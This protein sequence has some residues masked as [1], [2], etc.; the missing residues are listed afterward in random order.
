[1]TK[2]L[3]RQKVQG[4]KIRQVI[5]KNVQ[6]ERKTGDVKSSLMDDGFEEF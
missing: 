6:K 3:L 5:L 2:K 1:M 4:H